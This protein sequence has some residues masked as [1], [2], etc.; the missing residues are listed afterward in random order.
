LRGA[1]RAIM[2]AMQL[3]QSLKAVKLAYALV[4]ILA[5]AIAAYWY[6][7]ANPPDVP[8][9][10]PLVAPGI[11]LLMAFIRHI[12]RRT[13]KL[14][15]ETERI[16]YEAGLFAKTTRIMELVKVQDVRVDQ[17]LGQRMIN[18]GDLSLETAGESSRIVMASIDRPK[19]AAE[20]I[21]ELSRAL[22]GKT[23]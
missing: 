6:T 16:R 14:A 7:V 13:T 2:H 19:E 5:V 15:V 17:T 18:V 1:R 3:R 8:V 12:Q 20:H 4:L 22:R 23:S 10:V 21:L 9:W 11:L